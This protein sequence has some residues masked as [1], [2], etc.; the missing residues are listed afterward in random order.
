MDSRA[1]MVANA[2]IQNATLLKT[3]YDRQVALAKLW[4]DLPIGNNLAAMIT[5]PLDPTGVQSQNQD[6]T[7]DAGHPISGAVYPTLQRDITAFEYQQLLG[8]CNSVVDVIEGKA[9]SAFGGARQ[10]LNDAVGG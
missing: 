10:I 1:V 2:Q 5:A 6:A 8:L 9:V 7:P 3:F 4:N